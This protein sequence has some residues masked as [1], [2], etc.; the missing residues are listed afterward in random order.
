[1]SAKLCIEYMDGKTTIVTCDLFN[2]ENGDILIAHDVRG[3]NGK[4]IER[5]LY[6]MHNVRTVTILEG[7]HGEGDDSDV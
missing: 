6:P 4:K 3:T 5:V 2:D 7:G 1:M